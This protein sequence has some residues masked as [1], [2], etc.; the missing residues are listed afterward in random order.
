MNSHQHLIEVDITSLRPTQITVGLAEVAKK[1]SEWHDL[2]KIDKEVLKSREVIAC[3]EYTL[4]VTGETAKS[5]QF[6]LLQWPQNLQ[7]QF[8]LHFL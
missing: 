5:A 4:P 2:G 3:S 6:L 7:K 1:R 8:N